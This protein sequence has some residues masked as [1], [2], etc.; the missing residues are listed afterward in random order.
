MSDTTY[1]LGGNEVKRESIEALQEIPQN[2]TLM[3]EKLTEFPPVKPEMVKGLKSINEAFEHFDPTADVTYTDSE[4][5]ESKETLRFRTVGDFGK[6]G[7]TNQ[8]EFL[9]DLDTEKKQYLKV[10][11]QLKTNKILRLA[12]ADPDAKKALLDTID[13]LLEELNDKN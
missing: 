2:R 13:G 3:I 7:I 6:N 12:L 9:K 8:S 11:K 5:M 4:G 1:G 10:V